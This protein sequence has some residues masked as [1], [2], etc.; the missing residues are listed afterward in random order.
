MEDLGATIQGIGITGT[1]LFA[2]MLAIISWRICVF[3]FLQDTQHAP[4]PTSTT[5]TAKLCFHIFLFMAALLDLCYYIPLSRELVSAGFYSAHLMAQWAELAAFSMIVILWARVLNAPRGKD[6]VVTYVVALDAF[7]L[8]Y[9]LIVICLAI[10]VQQNGDQWVT[11][12]NQPFVFFFFVQAVAL[13]ACCLAL[14]YHGISLQYL[15]RNHPRWDPIRRGRRLRTVLRINITLMAC[16]VCFLLRV[17][18]LLARFIQAESHQ[19]ARFS[20]PATLINWYIWC[21]WVPYCL[22]ACFLLYT[23]GNGGGQARRNID[24][25][26]PTSKNGSKMA[27]TSN[28]SSGALNSYLRDWEEPLISPFE[29][30]KSVVNQK[31]W[32]LNAMDHYIPP[33]PAEPATE[34]NERVSPAAEVVPLIE[35]AARGAL[36]AEAST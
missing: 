25:G 19:Q 20:D 14:L 23:V 10:V 17:V 29:T 36:R 12:S 34:I 5:F 31:I 8:I 18:L 22:P 24:G 1:F 7:T 15:V 11:S 4:L 30:Y 26:V 16:T 6:S 13:F 2:V 32:H 35:A 21:N 3:Y 33:H 28:T 27:M 9:T